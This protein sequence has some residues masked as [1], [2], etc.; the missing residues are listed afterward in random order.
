MKRL[1]TA[2]A[3]LAGIIV[4]TLWNSWYLESYLT[5]ISNLL[6]HAEV[7]AEE[8]DWRGAEHLT[9]E[10]Y[11]RWDSRHSY[12]YTVLRHADT[13]QVYASFREVQEYLSCQE[14]GEYSASNAHLVAQLD[15]L[16]EM[17]QLTPQNLL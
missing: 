7:L 1:W 9:Q 17:E 12:L 2:V 11:L 4:L 10:A 15:L 3:L 5:R 14:T 16:W 6:L 13:D 8:G